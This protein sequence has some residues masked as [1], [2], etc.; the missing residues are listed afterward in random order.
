MVV[1]VCASSAVVV[2][3][4]VPLTAGSPSFAVEVG[5]ESEESRE[6][7]D[8]AYNT[9]CDGANARVGGFGGFRARRGGGCSDGG[10]DGGAGA[11][12]AR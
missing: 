7:D 2:A 12:A 11:G 10:G 5:S 3:V 1:T 4:F 8:T 9:A 6:S